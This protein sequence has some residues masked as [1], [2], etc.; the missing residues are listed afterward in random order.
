MWK[1]V[2]LLIAVILLGFG[3]AA[4]IYFVA[5]KAPAA[6]VTM[7]PP[8]RLAQRP[9]DSEPPLTGSDS[10]RMTTATAPE[11]VP[12]WFIP[13]VSLFLSFCSTVAMVIFGWR[14]ELRQAAEFKLRI[15]ELEL[16]IAQMQH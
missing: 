4:Y 12:E 8:A 11:P 13:T 2:V 7:A 6:V 16:Q 1:R 15:K 3:P 9:T 14:A 10:P 5:P